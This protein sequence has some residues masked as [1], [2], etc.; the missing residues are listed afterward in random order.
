MA[1]ELANINSYW[2]L[3]PDQ[4][5]DLSEVPPELEWLANTPSP[6]TRRAYKVDVA[7]FIAFTNLKAH[8]G[9]RTVALCCKLRG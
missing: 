5:R 7:E 3:T 2:T 9:L 6:K 8:S 1:N 4:Y